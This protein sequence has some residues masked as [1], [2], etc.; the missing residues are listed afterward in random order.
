MTEELESNRPELKL[1]SREYLKIKNLRSELEFLFKKYEFVKANVENLSSR[2][3]NEKSVNITLPDEQLPSEYS[4]KS[5][6]RKKES[7]LF[8]E[9][10]NRI[11]LKES[12]NTEGDDLQV[13]I[14][15]KNLLEAGMSSV[16]NCSGSLALA[17]FVV[18][19]LVVTTFSVLQ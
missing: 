6:A 9:V 8:R 19:V 2:S 3:K 18:L 11:K 16:Q 17:L 13:K 1:N 7:I 10:E 4:A 5:S 15:A 12:N 14:T